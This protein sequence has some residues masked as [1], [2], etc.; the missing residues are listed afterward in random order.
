LEKLREL[1]EKCHTVIETSNWINNIEKIEVERGP[2]KEILEVAHD[3][4]VHDLA[5]PNVTSIRLKLGMLDPQYSSITPERVKDLLQSLETIVPGYVSLEG[6][7][8]SMSST[9]EIILK[10][11]NKISSD[12]NLPI[13]FRDI[14]LKAFG[15]D[16]SGT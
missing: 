16:S 15:N 12:S 13:E 7:T 1:F 2:F 3:L 10:E 4:T 6:D 11:I 14:Y 8:F 5:T 9:P